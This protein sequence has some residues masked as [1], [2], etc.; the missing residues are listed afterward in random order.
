MTEACI[1]ISDIENRPYLDRFLKNLESQNIDL[2]LFEFNM[3]IVNHFTIDSLITIYK[4]INKFKK[5]NKVKLLTN[6]LSI[7]STC[8]QMDFSFIDE[9]IY[10]VDK[11]LDNDI[12]EGIQSILKCLDIR[13]GNIRIIYEEWIFLRYLLAN[14]FNYI[15]IIENK[16][17]LMFTNDTFEIESI[18]NSKIIR[19]MYEKEKEVS[20]VPFDIFL[21][22]LTPFFQ[23]YNAIQIVSFLFN[24]VVK[25]Y[26][27]LNIVEKR[28]SI[29]FLN[30]I[31]PLN[32]NRGNISIISLIFYLTG[33]KDYVKRILNIV[34]LGDF[35]IQDRVTVF[36]SIKRLLFIGKLNFN[37]DEIVYFRYFYKSI[38]DETAMKVNI[39]NSNEV[40]NRDRVIILTG[41]FLGLLHAP[42]RNVLDYAKE[43]TKLG[44]EVFIINS[45]DVISEH[46]IHFYNGFIGNYVES[47]NNIQS[48]NFEKYNFKFF[49]TDSGIT[50]LTN[51]QQ[52][53]NLIDDYNPELIISVGD[54]NLTAD[55]NSGS[56]T[57]IT[58]PCGGILPM[59][60]KG[61]WAV[62]RKPI[63][64]DDEIFRLTNMDKE[65]VF[66][67]YYS[68]MK[69]DK[70]KKIRRADFNISDEVYIIVV[71]GNRLN[72]EIDDKFI[73]KLEKILLR[74][75]LLHVVF[76][77]DFSNYSALIDT[78][79]ILKR[80]STS[81]GFQE[82]IQS[83][84][85]IC[86]FYMN[87]RRQGGAT[88]AAE[89][90]LEGLP[91]ISEPYGDVYNQLWLETS[92]DNTEDV[93]SY[94]QHCITD[95]TYYSS[96]KEKI[97]KHGEKFFNTRQLLIS[98]INNLDK[99]IFE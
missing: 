47:Y 31:I 49:Q 63:P 58:I 62:P 99:K 4:S 11:E 75:S 51:I 19:I 27:K 95:E 87:P 40:V 42:T 60:P 92:F 33:N 37:I 15:N 72:E 86:N 88:S 83:I 1:V 54:S 81:L 73:R 22:L 13:K 23:K 85:S 67:I 20:D 10:Y 59:Y 2:H 82:N 36:W 43:L 52:I 50:N 18:I 28:K 56:R 3:E 68:F 5:Y 94:I 12:E 7:L 91:I 32:S 53:L 8:N 65:C 69:K 77:G 79:T 17:Y 46:N 74:N 24:R 89:A 45:R 6:N 70:E 61:Y 84:Y 96:E 76:I 90:M 48:I 93:I 55:I 57:L 97:R 9:Y 35:S 98:L 64:S 25:K 30:N 29:D 38:V 21:L 39:Q 14:Y 44:K 41:Q 34:M 71:V 16:L 78:N 80:Q 66:P 26:S